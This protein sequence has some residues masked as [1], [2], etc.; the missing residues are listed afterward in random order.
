MF[1][2]KLLGIRGNTLWIIFLFASLIPTLSKAQAIDIL[3]KGGHV[4]DPKNRIDS[5]MDVAIVDG[6][7]FKVAQDISAK[8]A[9]KVVNVSGLYVTPGL[10]NIHTH[11]FVGS[12]DGFADGFDCVDPDAFSFRSGVTT[13]VDAGTSGWKNFPL[14]KK[15]VID[16]SKTRVLAFLDIFDLG[17]SSGSPEEHDSTTMNAEKISE[18]IKNYPDFIVGVC[19]GHYSGNDWMPFKKAIEATQTSKTPILVETDVPNLSLEGQLEHLR[20]GDIL[21]NTYE[22]VSERMSVVDE[23]GKVRPF[24]LEAQKRGVLFDAGHGGAGFWFSQ[25]KPALEQGLIPNSFGTDLHRF[26]MNSGMKDILNLMSKFLNMGMSLQAVMARAAWYPALS[27]KRQD[28]GNLSVGSVADIA[29][30]GLLNGKF[31]FVD[32]GNNRFNGTRKFQAELTI[33]GGKVVYDLNGISA[34]K[35]YQ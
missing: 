35:S 23:N 25:A 21:T 17:F 29:V 34:K 16:R 19:V 7:I 2:K 12:K 8:D 31:G 4:I 13:M 33:R 30:L 22:D 10:I 11:V 14:F 18:T 26:S 1:N 24:V 27:I 3:L 15:N 28:L 20:K 32:S 9:K 5:K 6:K